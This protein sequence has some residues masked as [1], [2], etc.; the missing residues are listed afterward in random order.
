MTDAD[1][2]GRIRRF[3][4]G[5]TALIFALTPVELWLADHTGEPAQAIPFVLCG[6]G[7]AAVAG[8]LWRPVRWTLVALRGAMVLVAAG[9]VAGGALHLIGN[10]RF[11][12]EI[13]PSATLVEAF[14]NGLKGV[15]PLLAPGLLVI[16]ALIALAATYDHPAMKP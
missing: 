16:A 14:L 2:T 4:L 5:L 1:T 15:N 8:V 13:R 6:L 7:L 3:L 10:V 12:Q 9:G 11:E